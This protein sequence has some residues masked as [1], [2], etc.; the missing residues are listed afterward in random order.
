M[1]KEER[2]I[3]IEKNMSLANSIAMKFKKI[4]PKQDYEEM[5]QVGCIGLIKAVN[6]FDYSKD[7]K[8]STYA[9][10]LIEGEIRN[11]IFRK[12][13]EKIFCE[14]IYQDVYKSSSHTLRL[15]D[16]IPDES[17]EEYDFIINDNV[18]KLFSKK[19]TDR[20]KQV[21]T[22][23]HIDDLEREKVAKILGISRQGVHYIEK[24]GLNKL[25]KRWVS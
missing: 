20:E 3:T 25:R 16:I 7:I 21:V 8:F 5:F 2:S 22:M 9:Y 6:K 4:N 14:D 17:I 1:T 13:K 11:T 24:T 23:I 12:D 19:I 10:K 15:Q 18:N